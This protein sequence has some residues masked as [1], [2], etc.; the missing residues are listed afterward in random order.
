MLLGFLR[1]KLTDQLLAIS[2]HA[3]FLSWGC[4]LQR[5]HIAFRIAG[6]LIVYSP[7]YSRLQQIKRKYPYLTGHLWRN[8]FINFNGATVEV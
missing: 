7:I 1:A 5:Q 6:K 3:L 2:L 4:L 8:S